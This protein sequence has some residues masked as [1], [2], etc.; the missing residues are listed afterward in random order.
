MTLSTIYMRLFLDRV[1]VY[2]FYLTVDLFEQVNQ[3][4]SIQVVTLRHL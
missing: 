2:M 4:R 1:K 3:I